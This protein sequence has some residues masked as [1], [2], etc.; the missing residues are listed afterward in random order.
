MTVTPGQKMVRAMWLALH[1]LGAVHDPRD[2]AID[3]FVQRQAGVTSLRF[4]SPAT[5]ARVI[6]ALRDWLEREGVRNSRAD[7]ATTIRRR[8][9]E[10]Q[11]KTLCE[12]GAVRHAE[13]LTA[14]LD[15][16]RVTPARLPLEAMTD[17]QLDRAAVE[18]GQW[19]RQVRANADAKS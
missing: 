17:E 4:L 11:W 6:Q 12:L 15:A 2:T 8:F 14:W 7:D 10:R 5:Q 16:R 13:A 19:L 1:N 3:A 9:V 18:L